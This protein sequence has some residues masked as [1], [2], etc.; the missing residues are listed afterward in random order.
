MRALGRALGDV[1][2]FFGRVIWGFMVVFSFIVNIVLVAVIAVLGLL[3][4]NIKNDVA[5]PLLKGLHSSFVGLD[6]ATIDWTIPVR[7]SVDAT[8]DLPL[9]QDTVVVLTAD[10]PLTVSADIS[11]PVSINNATV[12]L[13]LPE[14]LNLPVALDLI[15]PVDEEIP[16][17][18]DVRA[19]I[20]LSDTQLHDPF[21]NLRLTFE[22]I[23]LALD[24]L[25]ND[26]GEAF[27]FGNSIVAQQP[28]NL[29]DEAGSQY[30]Q[31]P[32]IG[33]SRTAGVG[34]E[35]LAESRQM[36]QAA[37]P[38]LFASGT[39]LNVFLTGIVPKGG[40]PALDV[41]VRPDLY[42]GDAS[43]DQANAAAQTVLD[44][45]NIPSESYNGDFADLQ[46]TPAANASVPTD[47]TTTDT[48]AIGGPV[49]SGGE[50][51]PGTPQP[52]FTVVPPN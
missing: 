28:V 49:D 1:F 24:N 29:F 34:Y 8:F 52:A 7:D 40:I 30:V 41:P 10:V 38:S 14:G 36:N 43:P 3:L 23:I 11:G 25:P 26:F 13:T 5:D 9:A 16:V 46:M 47:G 45:F 2:G 6:Q 44:S 37:D 42:D 20:P 39:D 35:L 51:V 48:T 21:E 50:L 32:W 4:F 22:P 18:L 27:V 17:N 33:F 15:V 31:S 12:A 19:V